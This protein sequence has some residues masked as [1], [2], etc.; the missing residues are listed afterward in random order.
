MLKL[1]VLGIIVAFGLC[2]GLTWQ[3]ALL[4]GA[5]CA[6]V[7]GKGKKQVSA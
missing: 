1:L 5:Y 4:I 7:P 3:M 2:I 6:F